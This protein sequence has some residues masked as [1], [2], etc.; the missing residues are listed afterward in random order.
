MRKGIYALAITA[1]MVMISSCKSTQAIASGKVSDKL[2]S[3]TVIKQ[4]YKNQLDFKTVRG[5]LQFSYNDGTSEMSLGSTFNS[6]RI[7]KDSVIWISVG[8]GKVKTKITPAK[9]Q[10]YNKQDNTYFD[11]DFSFLSQLL[12][13]ELNFNKVQNLLLGQSI[14]NLK[15]ENFKMKVAENSYELKPK[16]ELELFKRLF[17][18]EPANFKMKLQQI[19]QPEEGRLMAVD[20]KSYQKIDHQVMPNEILIEVND[21]GAQKT[22]KVNYKGLKFGEELRFPFKIPKGFT[23]IAL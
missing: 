18:I 8:L 21:K 2:S 17:Q 12:G 6:F 5:K 22:I 9:V 11:G 1:M 16:K 19:S 3:R 4:H 23:K 20:Y 15:K 10:F 7:L 14:F 13:T